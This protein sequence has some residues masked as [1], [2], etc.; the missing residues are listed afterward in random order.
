[1]LAF[2]KLFLKLYYPVLATFSSIYYSFA[3]MGYFLFCVYYYLKINL[4]YYELYGLKQVQLRVMKLFHL[5]RLRNNIRVNLVEKEPIN[6]DHILLPES[7]I[8]QPAHNVQNEGDEEVIQMRASTADPHSLYR[9]LKKEITVENQQTIF[10]DLI[11]LHTRIR[12]WLL[13]LTMACILLNYT[14]RLMLSS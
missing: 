7:T 5:W 1:M 9:E 2:S 13:L 8:G 11:K 6:T 12:P 3:T 14:S 4:K 10:D